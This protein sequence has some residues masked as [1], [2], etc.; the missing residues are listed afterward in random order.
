MLRYLSDL[1]AFVVIST[2]LVGIVIEIVRAFLGYVETCVE[3]V[4]SRILTGFVR[5]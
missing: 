3:F 1:L 2:G 5:I 4:T